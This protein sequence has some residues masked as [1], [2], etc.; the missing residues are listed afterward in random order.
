MKNV[1][2]TKARRKCL[3]GIKLDPKSVDGHFMLGR[4]YYDLGEYWLCS[5]CFRGDKS[6]EN[7]FTTE[8]RRTLRTSWTRKL[9][10]YPKV[11]TALQL[12]THMV[13]S[14]PALK[15][16]QREQSTFMKGTRL[17]SPP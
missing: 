14:M 6:A 13:F 16:R 2:R 5:P 1:L 9:G 3:T 15:Q 7:H 17:M 11:G 8:A 10:H 4:L 12:K